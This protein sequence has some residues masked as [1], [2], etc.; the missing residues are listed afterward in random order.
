MGPTALWKPGFLPVLPGVRASN[1]GKT[2]SFTY[3]HDRD[4]GIVRVLRQQQKTHRSP[5]LKIQS[6]EK[7]KGGDVTLTVSGEPD[8]RR[9]LVFTKVI[10]TE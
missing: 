8:Y 9:R 5:T 7:P 2:I 10:R 1:R 3:S 6:I 4:H